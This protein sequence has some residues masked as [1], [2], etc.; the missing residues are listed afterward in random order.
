MVVLLATTFDCNGHIL[1][2]VWAL[3]G[4]ENKENWEW[5]MSH[6]SDSYL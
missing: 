2:L 5:F 1:L 3:V 6:L 4:V